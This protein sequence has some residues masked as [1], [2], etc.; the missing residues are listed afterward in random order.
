[1]DMTFDVAGTHQGEPRGISPHITSNVSPVV[2]ADTTVVLDEPVFKSLT[3][4]GVTVVEQSSETAV[5]S[6]SDHRAP[7][8]ATTSLPVLKA[9]LFFFGNFATITKKRGTVL[10]KFI[11]SKDRK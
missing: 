5:T 4:E 10:K 1:M 8:A 9:G 7:P 11:R 2:A 6:S 3:P